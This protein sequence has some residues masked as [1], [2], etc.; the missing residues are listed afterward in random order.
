MVDHSD[1][2]LVRSCNLPENFGHVSNSCFKENV[3]VFDHWVVIEVGVI[4]PLLNGFRKDVL[5]LFESEL[6]GYLLSPDEVG[7]VTNVVLSVCIQRI[8]VAV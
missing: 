5:G 2:T 3:T 7:H 4:T 8:I 6:S 1:S